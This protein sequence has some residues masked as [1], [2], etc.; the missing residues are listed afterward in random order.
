MTTRLN[1]IPENNLLT[2]LSPPT[3]LTGFTLSEEWLN[4]CLNDKPFDSHKEMK[5]FLNRK[6]LGKQE[7]RFIVSD[8]HGVLPLKLMVKY[9]KTQMFQNLSNDKIYN[10][11]SHVYLNM[12]VKST[13]PLVCGHSFLVIGQKSNCRLFCD[14]FDYYCL[15]KCHDD[16][17]LKTVNKYVQ[18]QWSWYLQ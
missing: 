18:N 16:S 2:N 13:G 10:F 9:K 5:D 12:E 11:M 3:Q 14:L 4:E 8:V 17:V 15:I 1:D 7:I 6:L